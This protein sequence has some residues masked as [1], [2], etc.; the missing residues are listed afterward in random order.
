MTCPSRIPDLDAGEYLM[1]VIA[2]NGVGIPEN[3]RERIFEPFFTTKE[4]GE[5]TGMRLAQVHGIVRSHGGHIRVEDNTPCG[6]RF[7]VFFPVVRGHIAS[8]KLVEKVVPGGTET[9]LVVV[10]DE[11]HLGRTVRNVL[12]EAAAH[13][14]SR[15]EVD[16][17]WRYS[18]VKICNMY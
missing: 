1:L 9:I 2:D 6:T 14:E 18:G 11:E 5:G 17:D 16:C 15:P 4:H 3:I 12:D 13:M 10:D 7:I 8:E